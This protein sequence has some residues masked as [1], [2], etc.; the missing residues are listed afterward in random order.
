M[1]YVRLYVI[2]KVFT[3]NIAC[4]GYEFY[5]TLEQIEASCVLDTIDRKCYESSPAASPPARPRHAREY[6]RQNS[7]QREF[8]TRCLLF[9]WEIAPDR[10]AKCLPGRQFPKEPIDSH[11]WRLF[12]CRDRAGPVCDLKRRFFL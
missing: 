9:F 10:E 4:G 1:E 11:C 6:T 12:L 3:T 5:Y 7:R 2:Y 8:Y